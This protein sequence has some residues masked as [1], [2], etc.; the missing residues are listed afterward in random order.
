MQKGREEKK[1]GQKIGHLVSV[2]ESLVYNHAMLILYTKIMCPYCRKVL[3]KVGELGIAIDERNMA[4]PK[5]LAELMEKGGKRQVPF[6]ID[7]EAGVSMYESDDIVEYLQKKCGSVGE[8][9]GFSG[10]GV[11]SA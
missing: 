5:N 7:E 8:K 3:D 1:E 9:K 6:L 10:F 2:F 11:C 4:D